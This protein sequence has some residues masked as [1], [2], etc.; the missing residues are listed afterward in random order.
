MLKSLIGTSSPLVSPKERFY[1]VL[2]EL[3]KDFTRLSLILWFH[4][5]KS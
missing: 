5:L 2:W 4:Q 3:G 1:G